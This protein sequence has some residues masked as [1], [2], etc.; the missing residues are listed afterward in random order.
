M[1]RKEAINY[2]KKINKIINNIYIYYFKN[3][4]IFDF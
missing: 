1:R 3:Y 2:K 4:F